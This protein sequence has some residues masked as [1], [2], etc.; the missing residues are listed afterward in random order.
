[1]SAPSSDPIP[2]TPPAFEHAVFPQLYQQLRSL[3]RRMLAAERT[4]HTLQA[5]A[6]VHEAWLGLE[7]AGS[8]AGHDPRQF[9]R[10]AAVAMRHILVEH[11]RGRGRKKRGG[12]ATRI[13]LDALELAARGDDDQIMAVDDAIRVLAERQ[14]ELAELVELRFFAGMTI[15]EVAQAQ[16]V[17][18][19]TVHR[20][21]QLA[22]AMLSR[23]LRPLAD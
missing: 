5:T 8:T 12:G 23:T 20:D 13:P 6:L 3:A 10:M 11:A 4:G 22:K 18:V 19:R 16:G 15:D 1:M 7:R 21:W 14:P 2:N 9:Q 17:S